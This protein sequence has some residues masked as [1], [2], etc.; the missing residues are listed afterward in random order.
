MFDSFDMCSYVN[1][2]Y[3][4]LEIRDCLFVCFRIML[5]CLSSSDSNPATGMQGHTMAKNMHFRHLKPLR[6]HYGIY[7]T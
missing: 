3:L 7:R 5:K 1:K 4:S 2:C 6:S